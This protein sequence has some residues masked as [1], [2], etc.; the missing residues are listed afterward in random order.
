MRSFKGIITFLTIVSIIIVPC[1]ISFA[2][3]ETFKGIE[4]QDGSFIYGK[5]LKASIY[6]IIVQDKDGRTSTYKFDDV[7]SFI[8]DGEAES[9]PAVS[10]E[11]AE[12]TPETETTSMAPMARH[13]WKFGPELS[14]IKYKEPDVMEQKGMMYG[15]VGSYTYHN[16]L[17]LKGEGRF[18]YGLLDYEGATF[19]GTP[20]TINKIPNYIMEFRGLI[21]YDFTVFNATTT[22]TPYIGLG[23]RYLDDN[24]QKKS[25]AGYERES[26]YL[27]SPIGVEAVN[28]LENGWS[29]GVS[30]E[31]DLFWKGRQKSYLSNFVAGLNNP[32]NDQNSGY[33]L[34]GSILIKKIVGRMSYSLE[35][36]IRYWNIDNSDGQNMTFNG[37]DTGV[38]LYEPQNNSTEVGLK[39]NVEF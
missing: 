25:S 33:G 6:E 26:N 36:F 31:Y 5:I 38:V 27:Y 3:S 11:I 21:G 34:R 23:Y 39:F 7:R 15:I 29:W 2:Q 19:G 32:E 16:K 13:I 17:M 9:V 24:S 1:S 8:K 10:K 12:V 28:N 37:V 14:Y 4:L 35:P 18:G 22:I 30:I 20:I